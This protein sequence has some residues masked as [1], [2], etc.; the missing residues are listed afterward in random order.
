[1]TAF[2]FSRRRFLADSGAALVA[3][4]AAANG[5][6]LERALLYARRAVGAP[7]RPAF[8]FFTAAQGADIE[9]VTEQ[10]WPADDTPGARDTGV[11]YFIDHALATD[12][13]AGKMK[14]FF[15]A[16]I[17]LLQAKV[18][19]LFPETPG[20]RFSSL[21]AE[22]QVSVLH[23]IAATPFFDAVR[24]ATCLALFSNPSYGANPGGKHWA[25]IG[26]VPRFVWRPP[27]GAYDQDAHAGEPQ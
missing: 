24:T 20:A 23:A 9:A 25:A 27:F 19:E 7:V 13:V 17:E 3:G 1:M 8:E 18:A 26:F 4:W 5:P 12:P 15:T 2:D 6:A 11:V 21:S 14:P 22:R 16:G 10:I